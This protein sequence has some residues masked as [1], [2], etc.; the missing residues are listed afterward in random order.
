M[1]TVFFYLIFGPYCVLLMLLG[2]LASFVSQRAFRRCV[3]LWGKGWL[4]IAGTRVRVHGREH[5]PPGPPAIYMANHQSNFDIPLLLTVLDDHFGFLAKIELYRVPL[6]RRSMIQLNCLPIDRSNRKKAM[7]SMERAARLIHDGQSVA[8][9]PEGT[10]SVDGQLLSFK[11]GGFVLALKAGVPVVPI[12][13]HGTCHAMRKKS[14][15]IRAAR[16]DVTICPP[17]PTAG[18]SEEDRDS[19]LAQVETAIRD[20]LEAFAPSC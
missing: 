16:V 9:F 1:R 14:W 20:G 6:L 4:A 15:C 11:K 13:I 8:L 19:L 17:I 18:L 2:I 5:L 3:W 10:R 12:A 7:V